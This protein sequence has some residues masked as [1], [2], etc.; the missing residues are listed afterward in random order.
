MQTLSITRSQLAPVPILSRVPARLRLIAQG[1]L[2]DSEPSFAKFQTLNKQYQCARACR[3]W[4]VLAHHLTVQIASLSSNTVTGM[5][6]GSYIGSG[7]LYV[8]AQCQFS[9]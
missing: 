1:L 6:L 2:R 9:K 8:L 5:Q 7:P 4:C 3:C